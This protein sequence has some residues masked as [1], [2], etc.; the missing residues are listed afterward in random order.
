M[1]GSDLL[2]NFFVNGCEISIVVV[3]MIKKKFVVLINLSDCVYIEIKEIMFV[4]EKEM[5][6]FID[7][8]GM[9]FF[10]NKLFSENDFF[11]DGVVFF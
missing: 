9:D 8:I 7:E 1:F 5:R 3:N 4:Y 2:N 11:I 10:L 6:I